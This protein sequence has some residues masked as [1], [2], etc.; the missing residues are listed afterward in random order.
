MA[1]TLEPE[2]LTVQAVADRLGVDRKA[3]SHHVGTREHLLSL[4]ALDLFAAS[5]AALR[6]DVSGDWRAACRSYALG[7]ADSLVAIGPFA[8][9]LPRRNP[10][11]DH[12]MGLTQVIVR[13]L[14]RAGFADEYAQRLLSALT[15]ICLGHARDLADLA[16]GRP[17]RPALVREAIEGRSQE[18][19]PDLARIVADPVDTY[20][21]VQLEFAVDT[22]L[23]GAEP[24]R[25]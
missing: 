7:L 1:R 9:Y 20:S 12:M 19:Y 25:A 10:L 21:R 5:V 11:G 15:S 23:R 4:A 2:K 17:S 22:F 18:E 16:E 13:K 3:I 8:G 14:C 24:K 6:I